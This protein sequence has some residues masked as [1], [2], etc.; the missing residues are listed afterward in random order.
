MFSKRDKESMWY[1]PNYVKI[2]S[3]EKNEKKY[4]KGKHWWD[5]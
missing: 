2:Y 4:Q 5:E 1:A 3:Q